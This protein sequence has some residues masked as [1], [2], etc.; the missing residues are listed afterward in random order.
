MTELPKLVR[1][2]LSVQPATV[3]GHPDADLLTAFAERSLAERER[4]HVMLHLAQCGECREVVALA[5]PEQVEEVREARSGVRDHWF[6]LPALRWAALAAGI[7]IAVS[8][9]TL[10]YRNRPSRTTSLNLAPKLEKSERVAAL[11][12]PH[13]AVVPETAPPPP[14]REKFAAKQAADSAPPA[15]IK[16]RLAASRKS[17]PAGIAAGAGARNGGNSGTGMNASIGQGEGSAMG[18]AEKPLAASPTIA[19]QSQAP[20]AAAPPA[21]SETVEVASAAGPVQTEQAE[22]VSN[23]VGRAKSSVDLPIVGRNLLD[24]QA[25]TPVKAPRWSIAANGQL[26]RSFDGGATWQDVNVTGNSSMSA[27]FMARAKAADS[28][29]A[30]KTNEAK[31]QS[32]ASPAP[33]FRAL[34]ANGPEVWV[35]GSGG[36]LYHTVDAGNS[37]TRVVPSYQ[38]IVLGGD[39]VAIEFPDPQHGHISTSGGETWTTGDGGQNWLKMP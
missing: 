10:E 3:S 32:A 5:L 2:R 14:T 1:H 38:G 11:E 17:Y 23:R 37:W 22:V 7:A 39:I 6:R 29:D 16:D 26:Q 18:G 25:S 20:S 12:S 33:A 4:D 13:P 30:M 15:I 34:A 24:A 36:A 9:G 8:V 19:A 28:A 31:K 27:N 21:V 35:G